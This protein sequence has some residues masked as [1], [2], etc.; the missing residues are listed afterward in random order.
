MDAER[1][2]EKEELLKSEDV[3]RNN[4]LTIIF[5][6]VELSNESAAPVELVDEV[7]HS[8]FFLGK[9]NQPPFSPEMIFVN[10]EE[11]LE[12]LK[13]S[14]P[15]PFDLYSSQLPKRSPFS[16]VLDMIVILKEEENENVIMEALQEL[17]RQ[18]FRGREAKPL[19]SSTVCVSQKDKNSVRY[20][21]VSMSTSGSIPGQ[22]VVAASCYSYWD[23]CVADAVMTYYPN[24]IKKNYFD[25]TIRLP[26][27]I[28]CQAFRLSDRTE[29]LPCVKCGNLFGLRSSGV[30]KWAY[31]NC[32]EVESVSNLVK[33]EREIK[34][35]VRPTSETLTDENRKRV[36]RSVMNRLKGLLRDVGFTWDN[37]VYPNI[38]LR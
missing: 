37:K 29:I 4:A 22:I 23:S 32:A 5:E 36:K 3:F 18:L 12:E 26:E 34:E 2:T 1:E 14:Y 10:D 24:T 15:R 7:L 28:R 16:C 17:N 13:L 38:D 21:G 27:T 31:G 9:I 19:I 20:Y 35:R 25:G 33:N 11:M 6:M 30:N 8:I